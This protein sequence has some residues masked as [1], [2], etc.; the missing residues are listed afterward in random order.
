MG[1]MGDVWDGVGWVAV[2]L[3][4]NFSK[5]LIHVRQCALSQVHVHKLF[6]V[7]SLTPPWW[8]AICHL[9]ITNSQC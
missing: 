9:V 6:T 2:N 5:T 3:S 4:S 7:L 1:V 8:L